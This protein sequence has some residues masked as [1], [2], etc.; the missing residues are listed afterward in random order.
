MIF[1]F[2][3]NRIP[4]QQRMLDGLEMAIAFAK[5]IQTRPRFNFDASRR[6]FEQLGPP[7]E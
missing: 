7:H 4:Y 6:M 2:R 1:P 5:S 3:G